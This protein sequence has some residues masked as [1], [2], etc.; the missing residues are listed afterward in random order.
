MKKTILVLILTMVFLLGFLSSYALNYYSFN[1]NNEIPYLPSKNYEKL[2]PQDYVKED[3]IQVL[4]DRI[5]IYVKDATWSKYADTNS[6]DPLLDSGANGLE[7][8]ADCSKLKEGDVVAY[9]PSWTQGLI[10]HRIT[11]ISQD[12][13]GVYFKLKGDNSTISDP[14]K[15]R[16]SQIKYQLIG[17][18]Y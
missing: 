9:E 12:N 13:E 4:K 8:E 3:Q 17:V 5:I 15:V 11:K 14:E 1:E 10:V 16:C 6:M 7:I 2:S 18:I